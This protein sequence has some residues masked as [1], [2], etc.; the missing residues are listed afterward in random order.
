MSDALTISP[1]KPQNPAFDYGELRKIGI[2]HIEKTASAIWTDYNIHDPG[3]TTLELLCYVITDLSYRSSHSIPDLLATPTDTKANILGHF[4]SAARILPNK[5]VTINDYRKLIIDI[6]GVKNAWLQKRT[7]PV[8][9]NV[10]LK[11]LQFTQPQN[12]LSEPVDVRGYYD[13]LLEFDTNVQEETKQTIRQTTRELLMANR[14][15]CEDF[16]GIDEVTKQEFRI[17]A[18]L[19]LKTGADP[20]DTVA[21]LFFNIQL[22]LTPLIRFYWLKDLLKLDYTTDAIFEGPLLTHGFIKEQELIDSDLKNEIHLSDVMQQILNVAGVENILDIVFN[23]TDQVVEL[24]NKW[25]IPVSGGK[26]P[27]VNILSSNVL[28]YKNGIPLRP[29]MQVVKNRFEK[30]M[31]DHIVGNDLVK[32]E[33]IS[34]DIGSFADTGYYYSVQNHFPK[35]YG[36]S[37]WGLPGDATDERRA[38]AKQLQG[39]LYFFDQQLANY[40][41][42]LSHLRNLFST[43]NETSTYFAEVVKSFPFADDL[44]VDKDN[45]GTNI[46][47]AAENKTAFYTRRNLFLDHLLSRFSESF[48]DYVNVLYSGFTAN[49]KDVISPAVINQEDIIQ[50]KINFLK[51][52]PEYSCA[53][54]SG[55]NYTNTSQIW[56]TDNIS[57]LEKRLERLLGIDDITRRNLVNVFTSIQKGVNEFNN[58]AFWFRIADFR[59]GKVLLEGATKYPEP[60]NAGFDLEDALNLIYKPINFKLVQNADQTFA[61]QLFKTETVMVS[62]GVFEQKGVL[63][64]SSTAVYENMQAASVDLSQLTLLVTKSRA[65]EG[66]FL[67]EH[68]LLFPDQ[69]VNIPDLPPDSPPS[70][71]PDAGQDGFM[72][73]CVDESCKDCE[74]KDP[75]S[76]RISVVLPAYAPRFLNMG[77][78]EYSERTIRME[79]P[80][81]AFVKICW[82]SNEQLVE[83]QEAYKAWLEVKAK[84]VDD[85][86]NVVQNRFI[87]ILTSL[88]SI[89]PV[90]R[91]QDCKST[92]ERTLFILS[93]NALGTLKT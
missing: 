32:S 7:K 63:L 20:F 33:D 60:E 23:A 74:D 90:A 13:V 82:V 53:R 29:D 88:K 44:F 2:R 56:D 8:F 10:S 34:F 59:S 72:P 14:N 5:A 83:F 38:Q 21:E 78:R 30:L 1:E 81:H 35:N 65:D 28:I 42:Q 91:L 19:E 57:G 31:T 67:I 49:T 55:Y 69:N 24:P 48:F 93:R 85:P 26:Q 68:L 87:T 71:P 18:E 50:D 47:A 51:N 45:I 77:F 86:G 4:F 6:E 36:I 3:I 70:S 25:I 58:D 89:Y 22:Y 37:H 73:I 79:A 92:E 43:D 64:A 9:A 54:F 75:Y 62:E 66:L 84:L 17:C 80:S 16:L 76:F 46:Q 15:L 40:F 11:K 61:Y 12:V 27:V 52:Y 41:S 39:Y